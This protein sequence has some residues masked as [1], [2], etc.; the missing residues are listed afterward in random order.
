MLTTES[1]ITVASAATVT[2]LPKKPRM[3]KKRI[4]QLKRR[5]IALNYIQEWC[6][7]LGFDYALLNSSELDV[8]VDLFNKNIETKSI[9]NKALFNHFNSMPATKPFN[10]EKLATLTK[11]LTVTVDRATKKELDRIERNIKSQKQYVESNT[12]QIKD[13]SD[14]IEYLKRDI[15]TKLKSIDGFEN[16]ANELKVKSAVN[17][18][19][20]NHDR[21]K[22]TVDYLMD[23]VKDL[24]ENTSFYRLHDLTVPSC[25]TMAKIEIVFET[26]DV[27][28]KDPSAVGTPA[29]NLGKFL[30]KWRPFEYSGEDNDNFP[31]RLDHGLLSSL[32]VHP[33][34]DNIE[35]GGYYHPHVSGGGVCWGNIQ[36][37]AAENLS[38]DNNFQFRKSPKQVFIGLMQLLKSYNSSSPYQ[39]LMNF[40]LKKDPKFYLTLEQSF[41]ENSY[42]TLVLPNRSTQQYYWNDANR[43]VVDKIHPS[44]IRRYL[45]SLGR[46]VSPEQTAD[47]AAIEVKLYQKY[48]I[49]TN[50]QH[51][52]FKNKCFLKLN[53]NTYVEFKSR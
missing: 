53:D 46:A 3:T 5:N 41:R 11:V 28:I 16:L 27:L 40:R 12:R 21:I 44:S 36:D 30:I 1:T 8:F 47:H 4:E 7:N 6:S 20:E 45:N 19:I 49:G 34:K 18:P 42:A 26:S 50:F 33:Y 43:D 9:V 22:K 39:Q 25:G 37:M 35:C 15:E 14:S 38:Y 52:E 48:Y 2:A 32:G 29:F 51:R 10:P 13:Y 17:K 31:D 23:M 24:C